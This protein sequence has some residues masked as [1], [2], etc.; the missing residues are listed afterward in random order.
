MLTSEPIIAGYLD[1]ELARVQARLVPH[2]TRPRF[3]GSVRTYLEHLLLAPAHTVGGRQ[4]EPALSA[5]MQRFLIG[6]I[7]RDD[8]LIEEVRSY[9]LEQVGH[10]G[11]VLVLQEAELRS[12]SSASIG[13][14]RS[15]PATR[16]A[17]GTSRHVQRG[18]FLSYVTERGCALIDRELYLPRAWLD[19]DIRRQRAA[20]PEGVRFR[21]GPQLARQLLERVNLVGVEATWV[22]GHAECGSDGDLRRWLEAQRQRY[23]LSVPADMPLHRESRDA[24]AG[25]TPAAIAT[26]PSVEPWLERMLPSGAYQLW[27]RIAIE[28][29]SAGNAR[30]ARWLLVGWNGNTGTCSFDLCYGPDETSLTDLVAVAEAR[31]RSAEHLVHAK[32]HAGLGRLSWEA[33]GRLVSTHCIGSAGTRRSGRG[34]SPQVGGASQRGRDE[35]G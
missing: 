32:R 27:M 9:A 6:G 12:A 3:I 5:G 4:V 15:Q 29:G 26:Q 1:D 23:V 31:A 34:E 16:G 10:S 17:Q 14:Y 8:A 25:L 19:D 24:V 18:Y 7:W 28:P 13:A 20:I 35:R 11:G 21:T 2:V 22:T 33:L 30:F